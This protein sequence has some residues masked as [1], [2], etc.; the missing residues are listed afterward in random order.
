LQRL[1]GCWQ[2]PYLRKLGKEW[3]QT[4]CKLEANK[5]WIAGSP[6]L[7]T[8]GAPSSSSR[9]QE[10]LETL[11]VAVFERARRK[12]TR[13]STA[14]KV[15][16]FT[17]AIKQHWLKKRMSNPPFKVVIEAAVDHVVTDLPS[18][19]TGTPIRS[20]MPF[21]VSCRSAILFVCQAKPYEF[22]IPSLSLRVNTNTMSACAAIELSSLGRLF[23]PSATKG[24]GCTKTTT[25]QHLLR[26]QFA[27]R[28]RLYGRLGPNVWVS[29][30]SIATSWGYNICSGK[31]P[32][33]RLAWLLC[34][35]SSQILSLFIGDRA[36]CCPA[37]F[38]AS[39]GAYLK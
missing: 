33:L 6:A 29:E 28:L 22:N 4:I 39:T 24:K 38:F 27:T 25:T 23:T 11:T 19:N 13:V 37:I 2:V 9:L 10:D 20:L 15:A 16:A 36:P 7:G 18:S 35:P 26:S 1:H 31:S 3:K 30:S 34:Q 32:T 12:H 14:M 5:W 17:L 21:L 8:Q